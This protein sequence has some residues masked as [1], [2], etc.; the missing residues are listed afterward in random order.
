[1]STPAD[2]PRA[3]VTFLRTHVDHVVKLKFLVAMH[4]APSGTTTISFVARSLDV[5]KAQVRDMANELAEEGL[6]RVSSEQLELAPHSID[7]RLALAELADWYV[8]NRSAV[9][10][11]MHALGRGDDG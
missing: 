1:M 7:E 4:S 9:L 8:R 5:P 3:V 2:L 10:D 6:L 11:A